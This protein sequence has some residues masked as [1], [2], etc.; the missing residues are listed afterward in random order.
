MKKGFNLSDWALNHRSLVWYF[1]L[2]FLVAGLVSYLD[3]GRE[4]DPEFTVKTMVVQA[5]WPGASIDETLNQVTDRLE[6]KLEELDTLD[7]TRSVTTAGKSVVFVFLKDTTRAQDVK[8]SWT[9]VRHLLT[10]IQNTLPQGVYGPYFNDQ[11]GDVFGNIYAFTADGLSMRQLRDYA[12]DVR[13][14]ILTIPNAG[15]VELIGAQDEAIYLEFSTRQVAAL[16]L[17]QQAILKALQD[18]NAI[19]PSGVVQA[20]PER[21]SVRVSGQF[22]SEADLRAVNLR[23][24]NRFFRLSDVATITRGYVDPPTSIFRVNGEDAIGLGIGMKPNGNLLEFGAELDKMMDQVTAELPVGVKVFKVADQPQVVK[25][26]VSGF[27]QALFE[28]VVIVLAVSFV[29]LG[30]RAGFVVSL[31]I[32]L[33]LAITFL[34]MS[35]MDISLQR[36]SL[37]ALIIALGLLVDDA[38]IAVEMMVA[39]LEHGDPINKAA[40]YVYSHTAFPM[41]IGTLVTIAGFIPIGLNNSQAGEYTFT[42]FVVIAVSLLVSWVVAVLFAPLLG[43]TF[44]P[45]KMKPHEEKRS[46]FFEA[47]SRVLL[48]SMRHKWTTII[49]TIVLFV[50]SVFGMGFIERQFFPQSDRPELVLDWTLPQNSSIADTKAQMERFEETM[51][52][53]NPDVEHWSTYVGQGAI[54]FVLSFDVKPANPYFGQMVVVARDVEARDR[55]KAKFEAAFRKDYVGTDVYVKY[56]ELG[57]PVGRPVQYRISGPDVQKLRGIAQDFA[58]IL[59]ATSGLG[60]SIITGT[61]RAASFVSMSCRTRRASLVYR[62]RISQRRSTVSLAASRSRR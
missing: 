49:T 41:L 13:T 46:R 25:E 59:S 56:L 17:D 22:N 42:L 19:T 2:V 5:N 10:D 32:P 15:K 1:M 18:Q 34:S 50:I 62:P 35:L 55:L 16:G 7:Y 43:V 21:I 61:S 31:S 12:E 23:V 60:W 6:K 27:T 58:G 44:L 57:P 24:N 54:R 11:F 53:D 48:L 33:V 38:M 4:E 14:K 45:K 28:A 30:L 52:K 3:L 37:G 20:G 9:E 39:R 26:A 40:T 29:S 8:K 36:V 51:L 47:F